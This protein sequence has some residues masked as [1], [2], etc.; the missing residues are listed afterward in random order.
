MENQLPIE[1]LILGGSFGIILLLWGA[2]NIKKNKRSWNL[3]DLIL[4]GQGSGIGQFLSGV[5][6]LGA[7]IALFFMQKNG[8]I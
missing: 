5:L 1:M 2:Y 6:L 3:L 7:V 8:I 4:N